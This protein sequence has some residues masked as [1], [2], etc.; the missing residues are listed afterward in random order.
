MQLFLVIVQLL[1]TKQ[2]F[3]DPHD[4]KAHHQTT[5]LSEFGEHGGS[6]ID[7]KLGP[8]VLAISMLVTVYVD[9]TLFKDFNND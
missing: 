3:E 5:L 2:T 7:V 1:A 8:R 4:Q 6:V 9:S